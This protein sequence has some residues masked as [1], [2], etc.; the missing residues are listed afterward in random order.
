MEKL[1]ITSTI[2]YNIKF[3]M[4]CNYLLAILITLS[5]HYI[6]KFISVNNAKC[7]TPLDKNVHI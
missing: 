7:T 5:N 4:S 3:G 6:T 2:F 1:C